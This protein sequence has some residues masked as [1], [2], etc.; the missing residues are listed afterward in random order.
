MDK[1][2]EEVCCPKFNPAGWDEKMH[3]WKK[4]RFIK[5]SIPQLFHMPWP[6]MIGKVIE[7]MWAVAKSAKAEVDMKDYL[8]LM[9]DPSPWKSEFYMLVGKTVPGAENVELNGTFI[10]KVYEGPYND[11]PKWMANMDEYLAKKNKKAL[12]YYFYY[13][14]CP[15]CAKKWGKNYVVVFAQI[16]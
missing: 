11:V 10:S 2:E 13:T 5:D 3:V 1:K 7:R 8:L 14:T 9:Y 12:K 4:K 15:K 6:P 16:S